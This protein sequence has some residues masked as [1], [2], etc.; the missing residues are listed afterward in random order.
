MITDPSTEES[1]ANAPRAMR[2]TYLKW[3]SDRTMMHC[4]MR[5]AMNNEF[6]YKFKDT[7]SEDMIQILNESFDIPKD[8]KR[9]KIFCIVFNARMREE[10]SVTNYVLYMIEQIECLSKLDFSLHE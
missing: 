4:I 2:D 9:Y 5:V 7:Q 3:L 6:S 10:A 1:T 8:A